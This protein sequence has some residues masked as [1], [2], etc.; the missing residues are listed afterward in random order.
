MQTAHYLRLRF[1][2]AGRFLPAAFL[3]TLA[4]FLGDF[5]ALFLPA[6]FVDDELLP[7]E[8]MLSQLSEYCF[9]APMRTTLIVQL[10]SEFKKSVIKELTVL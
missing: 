7:P 1:A 6:F 10:F 4:V 2:P 3:A 5:F 8:K 9:V